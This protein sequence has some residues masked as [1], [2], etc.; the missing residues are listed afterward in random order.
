MSIDSKNKKLLLG[1]ALAGLMV[2]APGLSVTVTPSGG[3]KYFQTAE[4]EVGYRLAEAKKKEATPSPSPTVS[5]AP[6]A[7]PAASPAAAE[8]KKGD[9]SCGGDKSC[10]GEKKSE[11]KKGDK[12]EMSCG[13]GACG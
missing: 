11:G 4:L 9:K 5:P 8:K 7:A 2:A 3:A 10:A 1:S 12:G 13:P 6:A